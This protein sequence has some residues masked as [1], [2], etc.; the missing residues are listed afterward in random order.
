MDLQTL[1]FEVDA[2]KSNE[3]LINTNAKIF[4][5]YVTE[6]RMRR[7]SSFLSKRAIQ[8]SCAKLTHISIH[9]FRQLALDKAVM[10]LKYVCVIR[11]QRFW[12]TYRQLIP[13]N[14]TCPI[15]QEQLQYPYFRRI[16]ESNGK[17]YVYAY[18]VIP[19]VDYFLTIGKFECPLTRDKFVICHARQLDG[20]MKKHNI[21]R[22][23]SMLN[24]FACEDE[25]KKFELKREFDYYFDAEIQDLDDLLH[26]VLYVWKK[27]QSEEEWDEY[28]M[29]LLDTYLIPSIRTN[30]TQLAC[31]NRSST[32]STITSF[33]EETKSSAHTTSSTLSDYVV[34]ELTTL[35]NQINTSLQSNSIIGDAI[36]RAEAKDL[37]QFNMY[38][39]HNID[40]ELEFD[41]YD[42][43]DDEDYMPEDEEEEECDDN[44]NNGNNDE[45]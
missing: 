2:C 34:S 14:K 15:S 31:V 9:R 40:I 16:T 43:E 7:N 45:V 27:P 6:G 13:C 30:A 39:Q 36:D 5:K 41:E 26:L 3:F 21:K 42:D 8:E 4:G 23:V 24:C 38:E 28:V 11:I 17:I 12:R 20:I 25:H 10:L 22:R 44:D 1:L 29:S 32:L 35:T 37:S 19:L 18:N 33:I